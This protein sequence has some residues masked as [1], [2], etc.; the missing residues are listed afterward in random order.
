M[1]NH[2]ASIQVCVI[3]VIFPLLIFFSVKKKHFS[4]Q[5]KKTFLLQVRKVPGK[6]EISGKTRQWL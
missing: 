2:S 6:F 5:A 3:K 1:P 4:E